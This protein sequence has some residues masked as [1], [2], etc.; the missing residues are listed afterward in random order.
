VWVDSDV[1]KFIPEKLAT[2]LSQ[3]ET[4]VL[5]RVI[6]HGSINVNE[7]H[8]LLPQ[9]KTWHSVK[10]LLMRMTQKGLL[11]HKHRDDIERDPDA[12]FVLPERSNK[13]GND[14]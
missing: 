7:C 5:N 4:R 10:K 8:R 14:A 6:E 11:I 1:T 13:N 3:A 12:C 2:G 9:I